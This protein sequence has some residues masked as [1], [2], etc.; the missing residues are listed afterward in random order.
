MNWKPSR[1]AALERLNA[2][3]P[4]AGRNYATRRNYDYGDFNKN[5]VSGLSPWIRCGL[6]SEEEVLTAILDTHS[7]SAAEKF[8]MEVCWRGYFKGWLE[9]RPQVWKDYQHQS[10]RLLKEFNSDRRYLSAINGHTGI[11]CFDEWVHELIET[12][13]LHNHAR[14]W[15]ASIWIFTLKLPW[16]LGAKFFMHH[17]LDGD[18]AANTL[19]WRWVAGLHT[20]GKNYLANADNISKFTDG[21]F[22]RVVGLAAQ[23]AALNEEQVYEKSPISFVTE[24]TAN[25]NI[26]IIT[27]ECCHAQMIV[28]TDNTQMVFGLLDTSGGVTKRVQEFRN[29]AVGENSRHIADTIGVPHRSGSIQDLLSF[30]PELSITEVLSVAA[31]LGQTRDV[32]RR[33]DNKLRAQ[34]MRLRLQHRPYDRLVWPHASAGFFKLKK[35]IPTILRQLD[36]NADA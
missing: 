25:P 2:F 15:F 32:L 34:N 17:L 6:I 11:R 3:L 26:L 28:N 10:D 16:Q 29:Q 5:H 9:H 7:A 1:E 36:L 14:M 20:R 8:I 12:A 30:L 22:D 18:P 23:A 35:K 24:V 21:R 31:P 13:Y 4:S 19:S 27:E 33:L